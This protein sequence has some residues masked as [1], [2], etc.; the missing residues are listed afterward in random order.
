MEAQNEA[1][2]KREQ[3]GYSLEE[4]RR[5]AGPQYSSFPFNYLTFK[6]SHYCLRLLDIERQ[7]MSELSDE[8]NYRCGCMLRRTHD[9]PYAC[10]PKGAMES[11]T[12]AGLDRINIFWRTLDIGDQVQQH[13]FVG[14]DNVSEH[15][16][17]FQS[18]VDKVR[19]SDPTVVRNVSPII[20]SHLYPNEANY[21]E[22]EVNTKV[23]GRPRG[24]RSTRRDPSSWEYSERD[25]GRGRDRSSSGLS[26]STGCGRSS[27]SSV[28]N[29]SPNGRCGND[30]SKYCH[31][32]RIP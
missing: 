22:P 30:I 23:R 32:R 31:R 5:K 19:V 14:T 16:Q 1:G 2:R 3:L 24:S 29:A 7:R 6:V 15:H 25:R 11:N 18:L 12:N 4:S 17:Y 10:E 27:S 21:L 8:V 26:S 28:H 20:H 13:D 9:I